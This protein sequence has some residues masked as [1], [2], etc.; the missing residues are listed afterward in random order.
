MPRHRRS[1]IALILAAALLA[2]FAIPAAA[3]DTMVVRAYF[4][5]DGPGGSSTLVPVLR[6]VPRSTAVATAAV[7][8]LLLGPS[9]VERA[10]TP[11]VRTTIP[12]G[13]TLRGVRIG[14]GLATV[15]LSGRFDDGG[16]SA[17]MM[18]RLAQLTYTLT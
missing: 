16:G 5:L 7:R 11:R 13:V 10:A 18:G 2:A 12:A 4:L 8:Q 3:A 15:D 17:S 9:S 14:S 1:G 6:T